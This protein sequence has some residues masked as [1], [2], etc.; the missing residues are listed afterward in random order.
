MNP[1]RRKPGTPEPES[2]EPVEPPVPETPEKTEAERLAEEMAEEE[3]RRK[4]LFAENDARHGHLH[5]LIMRSVDPDI[6]EQ[7]NRTWEDGI[8][9]SFNQPIYLQSIRLLAQLIEVL[10]SLQPQESWKDPETGGTS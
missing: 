6:A 1:F 5:R 4:E 2:V 10:R 8:F 7:Y 3:A 9:Y